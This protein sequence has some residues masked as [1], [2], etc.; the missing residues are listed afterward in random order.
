[1]VATA[2]ALAFALLSPASPL[3]AQQYAVPPITMGQKYFM[4]TNDFSAVIGPD[5]RT[6]D[7]GPLAKLVREAEIDGHENLGMQ[8]IGGATPMQ[9]WTQGDGDDNRN[10]AKVALRAGGVD[11]FSM[12]PGTVVPDE[13]IELFADLLIQTNP[14]G[15]ILV[16]SSWAPWDGN[17][18]LEGVGS[19]AAPDF[20][21]E[22]HDLADV[23]TIQAWIDRL[24][25]RGGYL[26]RL[27][28]QLQGI[29]ERA[30]RPMAFVVPA[31]DA[32][33]RMRQEV[34]RGRIPGLD[35]Q[36]QLF[37]DGTGHPATPVVNLVTYV[38]FTVM[39]RQP[40]SGLT[41]LVDP[42]D[43]TSAER[44]RLLQ[45]IAWEVS[46]AERKSGLTSRLLWPNG[47]RNM[48]DLLHQATQEGHEGMEHE[49]AP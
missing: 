38:W 12:A 35:S 24:H 21:N 49:G 31:A 11:A 20:S 47:V 2:G 13:G 10:L 6:G 5:N 1:V 41:A 4:A 34:L 22:D 27:R 33:Y 9:H 40:A 46:A 17:G 15:R 37:T 25:E 14:Q 45:Q 32:V 18:T 16:Q 7:S 48:H 36:S 3:E 44:E 43:P 42:N 30:G 8:T 19:N 28:A 29:D 23:A 26:E 39:Y